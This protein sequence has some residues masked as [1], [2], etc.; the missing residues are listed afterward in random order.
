MSWE[1]IIELLAILPK[2]IAYLRVFLDTRLVKL[3]YLGHVIKFYPINSQGENIFVRVSKGKTPSNCDTF[4]IKVHFDLW[5]K[6][7]LDINN[8]EISYH[9]NPFPLEIKIHANDIEQKCGSSD[10]MITPI[11]LSEKNTVNLR[12]WRK[13]ACKYAEADK[14]DYGKV[15]MKIELLMRSIWSGIKVVY[16]TGELKPGGHLEN[17]NLF[18]TNDNR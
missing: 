14:A 17:I 6:Y 15:T 3:G 8:I 10:R 18:F 12:V 7:D 11:K 16:V 4:I 1:W 13:F 2:V 9:V 5:S